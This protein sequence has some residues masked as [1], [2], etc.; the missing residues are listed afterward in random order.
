MFNCVWRYKSSSSTLVMSHIYMK[1]DGI[2]KECT[3]GVRDWPPTSY[4]H[5]RFRSLRELAT[6]KQPNFG[7]S[8]LIT[9]L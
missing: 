5:N 1:L 6:I 7:L 3:F 4:D 9:T 2:S 8:I